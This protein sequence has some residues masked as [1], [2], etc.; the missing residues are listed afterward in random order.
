MAADTVDESVQEGEHPST[1]VGVSE[2][3]RVGDHGTRPGVVE[4]HLE[5][6]PATGEDALDPVVALGHQHVDRAYADDVGR[7][8][9][10]RVLGEVPGKPL[11]VL[12]GGEGVDVDVVFEAKVAASMGESSGA[13]GSGGSAT[14]APA[15]VTTRRSQASSSTCRRSPPPRRGARLSALR[16]TVDA[17][18]VSSVPGPRLA[19]PDAQTVGGEPRNCDPMSS[20]RTMRTRL[21]PLPFRW[22]G[23]GGRASA[24]PPGERP[25]V[26]GGGGGPQSEQRDRP[27]HLRGDRG[28]AAQNPRLASSCARTDGD[29]TASPPRMTMAN[30]SRRPISS[31][32]AWGRDRRQ[33]DASSL[34]VGLESKGTRRRYRPSHRC[35][36]RRRAP[37]GIH[38]LAPLSGAHQGR[39]L[40]PM[41]RRRPR[42]THPQHDPRPI[43]EA[44]AVAAHDPARW[45]SGQVVL[46]VFG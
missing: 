17:T 16:A 37:G 45:V 25:E 1:T 6:N 34:W 36:T 3:I 4:A 9:E 13:A 40:S 2:P 19:G 7:P 28:G 5:G 32:T 43:A 33:H 8:D 15:V 10:D 29:I 44:D 31:I 27:R 12:R 38:S 20:T 23:A 21:L 35:D 30:G 39:T 18:M 22:E 14:A 11:V 46:A 41:D 26:G 24:P 42:R